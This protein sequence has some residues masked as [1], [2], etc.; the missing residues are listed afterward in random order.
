MTILLDVKRA[1]ISKDVRPER[2][3]VFRVLGCVSIS[4]NS[5]YERFNVAPIVADMIKGR[6]FVAITGGCN[7][8][9]L[10]TG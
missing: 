2:S 4:G 7:I 6:S 5:S 10:I 1:A 8:V 3:S 9:V